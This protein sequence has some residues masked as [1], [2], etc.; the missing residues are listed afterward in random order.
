M[1]RAVEVRSDLAVVTTDNPRS[2]GP[3][4]ISAN[5]VAGFHDSARACV[6]HDRAEAIRWA[7][8]QA[9][10]GD[11]VIIAGKGHEDYQIIGERRN[12]FDDREVARH[13]L[14]EST[15]SQWWDRASA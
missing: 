9:Q 13:W 3:E 14:Y 4:E 8:G 12:Y 5:I 6:M 10:P 11:C 1:G 2:E 7:L 15:L